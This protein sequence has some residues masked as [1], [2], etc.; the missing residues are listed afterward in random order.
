[1]DKIRI[2]SFN[3]RGLKNAMKRKSMFAYFK[4]NK[5][6]VVCLQETHILDKDIPEW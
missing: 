6:D 3:A 4:K 2:V 1:M 5:Y